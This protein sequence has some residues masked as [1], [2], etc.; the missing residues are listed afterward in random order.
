MDLAHEVLGGQSLGILHPAHQLVGEVRHGV[1]ERDATEGRLVAAGGPL[2][3]A[4]HMGGDAQQP[5]QQA[6][7]VH[8]TRMIIEYPPEGLRITGA[9]PGAQGKFHARSCPPG[10]PSST[11]FP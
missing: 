11:G 8:R 1:A 10:P 3:V 5:G 4:Q 9:Q 7:P 6:W 2:G